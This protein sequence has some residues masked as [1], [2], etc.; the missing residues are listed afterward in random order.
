[1]D[2]PA[3]AD[4]RS[5]RNSEESRY[6]GLCLPH[7]L[8]RLPYGKKTRKVEEF[9]YEEGVDGTE[10][11]RYLRGNAAYAL[12]TRLTASFEEYRWCS[13]IRGPAGGGK[14][15]GLPVHTFQ[16]PNGDVA[17]KCPAE[18]Q[19]ID[20]REKELADLGF[21]P[22]V[23]CKGESYGAFFS[24]QSAEAP[25]DYGRGNEAAT[26]SARLSSQL[27]YTFSISR[28]A[29]YVKAMMRDNIGSYT[30][31][32]ETEL[33]LKNWIGR[34]V[35]DDPSPTPATKAQYPLRKADIEVLD[36]PGHPG[37]YRAVMNLLPHY[38]LDE[39]KVSLRLVADLPKAAGS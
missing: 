34:Y 31:R 20:T 39:I 12:A 21:I 18:V 8:V 16:T 38:Q 14:V 33:Q 9:D 19:V 28:F 29:H 27:P 2:T 15:E 30:S 23:H 6:V 36:V 10:H 35:T 25:K 11:S 7:V 4:W 17:M 37:A 5:F 3:Y 24:V 32:A 1:M 22:F 26:A 13:S